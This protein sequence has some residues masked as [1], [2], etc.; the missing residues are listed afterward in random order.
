MD[1]KVN[2]NKYYC[3]TCGYSMNLTNVDNSI[4]PKLLQCFRCSAKTFM[5]I[6]SASYK[7][8]ILGRQH[9]LGKIIRR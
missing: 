7:A 5:A 6:Y 2:Y 3:S 4:M 9:R 1:T 8:M